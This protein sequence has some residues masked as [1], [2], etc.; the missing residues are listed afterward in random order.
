MRDFGGPGRRL[1]SGV[2]LLLILL[3]GLLAV[4]G[5]PRQDA[6]PGSSPFTEDMLHGRPP[7]SRPL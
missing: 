7:V 5:E 6:K 3:A 4:S 2:V 1:A